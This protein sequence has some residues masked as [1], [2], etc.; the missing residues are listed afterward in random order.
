M[1]RAIRVFL[2]VTLLLASSATFAQRVEGDRAKA[3]GVYAAEVPVNGQSEAERNAGFARALA[4]VLGKLSGDR[5]AASRPGVGQELRRAKDYV[6]GYDYRQDEGVGPTGAPTYRT[7]LVVSFD[8]A[9]VDGLASVLGLPVWPTPRPKPVL[10]L[11]IDDGSGPRLVGL[12]QANAARSTLN[13]AIER[14]YRLGLPGGNAA[15]Q[16]V[17]GAIWRGD[18]AA[19]ARASARY[20][21]PMQLIGKLY[22]AKGGWKAD[23]IF[24]DGGK[25]LSNWSTEQADARAAMAGGADGAADALMRRYA[26]RGS[27]AGPPGVYRVAFTNLNSS[28][29]YIRLSG[30]LQRLAVVRKITPVRASAE[31]VEFDLD[32]IS[33]LQGL[34]RMTEGGDVVEA[35]EGLE[36]QPPVYRLR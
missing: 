12:N 23:W 8:Q 7:T 26:K 36:G 4:Q 34:R 13:R 22:R 29:D 2:A 11:A 20:S 27:A 35:Q 15:E 33:G 16:A 31:M 9:Q 28:D 19:V 5:G 17:V 10:W 1:V 14:G 32:L 24:V 6:A 21:P 25:V 30:Y 3:E 18:S